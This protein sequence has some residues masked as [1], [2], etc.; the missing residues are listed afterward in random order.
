MLGCWL[1]LNKFIS[2]HDVRGEDVGIVEYDVELDV[3]EQQYVFFECC[4][5]QIYKDHTYYVYYL[6]YYQAVGGRYKEGVYFVG[7]IQKW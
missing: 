6:K 4:N 5:Y 3:F 1:A 7:Y 2:I